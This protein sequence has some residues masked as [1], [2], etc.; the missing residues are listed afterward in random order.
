MSRVLDKYESMSEF[1]TVL[2]DA[3]MQ[4]SNDWEEDFVKKAKENYAQ[5]GM[6]MFWSEAQDRTLCRIAG[7]DDF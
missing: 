1:E 4:A 6:G 7:P 3:R 2:E 5:Y